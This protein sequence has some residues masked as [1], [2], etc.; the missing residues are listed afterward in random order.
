[1]DP[2]VRR[3]KKSAR[4][5][6]GD[7]S[8]NSNIKLVYRRKKLVRYREVNR[9]PGMYICGS[10]RTMRWVAVKH[11]LISSRTEV[12]QIISKYCVIVILSVM[13]L[14]DLAFEDEISII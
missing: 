13:V 9:I 5:K 3:R 12:K 14:T 8:G 1:M 2:V 11:S 6:D 7:N 10:L 4:S